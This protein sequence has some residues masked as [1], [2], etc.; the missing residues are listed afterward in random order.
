MDAEKRRDSCGHTVLCPIARQNSYLSLLSLDFT[1]F[2]EIFTNI[3]VAYKQDF[4]H[5]RFLPENNNLKANTRFSGLFDA[6]GV[7]S[8]FVGVWAA[9]I[10]ASPVII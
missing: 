7:L 3:A 8:F 1:G 5:M 6:V 10:K 2:L 4:Y 9:L